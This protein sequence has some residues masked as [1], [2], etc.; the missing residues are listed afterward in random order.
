MQKTD[1]N[2]LI[3]NG[4]FITSLLIANVLS[5]KIVSFWGMVI[6]AAIVAYPLTF[7][8]TDLIGEIWGKEQANKAVKLGFICQIASLVMI[9][10]AILL[11]V[12]PFADNQAE[13][14]SIMGQSFRVVAA[15]LVA[16]YCSQSWDVWIFHKIR[17]MS[18]KHKWIRNNVSTMT[19]QMIDTAIFITIAFIGVVPNIWTMIISQYIIKVVYA[20]LDTIPFYLLTKGSEAIKHN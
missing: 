19:S 8:M 4:L 7:L 5:A 13:F 16:Y 18:T 6:P 20:A 14:K 12:A 15:S 17:S 3:L 9:G 1:K 2:L 10:L 11:P